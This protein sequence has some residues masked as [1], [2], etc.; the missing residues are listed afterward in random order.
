MP[1]SPLFLFMR[2]FTSAAV[3]FSCSMTK[4][5]MAGSMAPQRGAHHKAIERREA[6]GG[7][8]GHA[9]VDGGDGAAVAQMAG[10]ELEVLQA[11]R[12]CTAA[13]R[14]ADVAV[15]G[16][17]G[18]VL[19]D[20]VLLVQL[21]GQGVHVG[22]R[23]HASG[24]T[25]C[26]TRPP[27][28]CSGMCLRQASMPMSAALLCRGASSASSSILAMTSSSMSTER[29]K[30]LP[31]CTTRWPTASISSKESMAFVGPLVSA[32]STSA[33]AAL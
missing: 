5:T 33:M 17:V 28:A 29:S 15:R 4:G 12:P 7:V 30:Y 3:R 22:L 23:R 13:A 9:V 8:H 24:R 1:K 18:A 16:A 2:S 25:R 21:V 19:A 11:A 10:D 6:H 26:R 27:W 14:S 20:G 31:P 32:S